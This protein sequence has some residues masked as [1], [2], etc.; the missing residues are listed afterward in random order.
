MSYAD[1]RAYGP[2]HSGKPAAPERHGIGWV[3]AL[4]AN[5]RIDRVFQQ[6]VFHGR[7]RRAESAGILGAIVGSAFTHRD[8]AVCTAAG[9]MAAIYLEYFAR[10][11]G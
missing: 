2:H 6:I 3:D 7:W 4:V 5:K 11:G 1:E 9:G 8:H 10:P